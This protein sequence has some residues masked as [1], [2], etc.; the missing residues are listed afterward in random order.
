MEVWEKV[1]LTD[2]GFLTSVHNEHGCTSCHG[3]ADDAATKDAAHDGLVASPSQ[4][5]EIYCISCHSVVTGSDSRSVHRTFKGID[6]M[7]GR[8]SGWTFDRDHPQY[9]E[10]YE[11]QCAKCHT[12]CGQCHVSRPASAGGGLLEG[13]KF[14]ISPSSI[15][16]CT[17]CHGSRV[18]EE[19]LGQ[20]PGYA[21]DVH[22]NPNAMQC[23]ACHDAD[24]MHASGSQYKKRYDVAQ[25]P[26]CE[27]CHADKATSNVFHTEHWDELQCNVCHSQEY[28]NCYNCHAG[29]GLEEP[30]SLGLKIG[31]NPIPSPRR[32]AEYVLLR[33]IPVDPTTFSD[34]GLSL[35]TF[36]ALPTWKYASPHNIRRITPQTD[37]S[38]LANCYAA[39]HENSALFL[40]ASDLRP[41]EVAANQGVIVPDSVFLKLQLSSTL[42]RS[43]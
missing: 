16:N 19:Y 2:A 15:Y 32:D 3:G 31:L 42:R 22:W 30:S 41:Y 10:K 4:Q 1:L 23:T 43:K 9:G 17:A 39:C 27:E 5:P 21:A 8:R 12:S 34:W 36:D 33:H 35:T 38:G 13:H 29:T 6:D 26:Q 40:R 14:K 11:K 28:K 18:G 20:R 37:S 7:L 24:E 25:M